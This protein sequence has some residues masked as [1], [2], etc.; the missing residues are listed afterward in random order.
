MVELSE[1]DELQKEIEKE[2]DYLYEL[3]SV[4]S[5]IKRIVEYFSGKKVGDT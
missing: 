3:S 2:L 1:I 5:S 4:L